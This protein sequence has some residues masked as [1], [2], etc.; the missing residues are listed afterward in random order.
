MPA[1]LVFDAASFNPEPAATVD[2]TVA[3]GSGLN[4][5]DRFNRTGYDGTLQV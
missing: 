3:A 5:A 2:G 4:E 1:P